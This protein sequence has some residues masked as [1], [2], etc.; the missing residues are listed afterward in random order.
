MIA[1]VNDLKRNIEEIVKGF[2]ITLPKQVEN[3]KFSLEEK[4]D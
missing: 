4:N 1:V 3:I 2:R